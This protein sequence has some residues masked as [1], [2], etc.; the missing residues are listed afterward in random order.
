MSKMTPS[1]T[2]VFEKSRHEVAPTSLKY[3]YKIK[4]V[5]FSEVTNELMLIWVLEPI[6]IPK[7]SFHLEQ[8]C[9]D[10]F[11]FLLLFPPEEDGLGF[12]VILQSFG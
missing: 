2:K 5:L 3:G 11:M 8:F 6:G 12:G 1:H 9:F 7:N 4:V 10:L